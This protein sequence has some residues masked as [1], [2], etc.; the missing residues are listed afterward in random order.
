MSW[1]EGIVARPLDKDDAEAWVALNE[2]VQEADDGSEHESTEDFVAFL[3][4]PLLEQ[5]IGIWDGDTLVGYVGILVNDG[6]TV[7]VEAGG[8]VRPDR[9]RAGH[10]GR[11][12]DWARR[13]AT[14]A[15]A[16]RTPDRPG[17][18]QVAA[19]STNAGHRAML[20]GAGFEVVRHFFEM[21]HDLS[22]VSPASVPEGLRLVPFEAAYSEETRLAHNEAFRDHWGYNPRSP[23]VWAAR[24]VDNP[25]FRPEMSALLVDGERVAAY[26][27]GMEYDADTAATGVR[28]CHI[29]LV[30]TRREYRGR[31]AAGA[32]LAHALTNARERGYGTASLGVDAESPTGALGVYER[33]G[34]TVARTE[35][36][37][38][39]PLEAAT[40]EGRR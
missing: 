16:E 17:E 20:E 25:A 30:G 3:A 21:E 36:S 37:Y 19:L 7:R 1:P 14:E 11:L 26:L 8:A 31:G 4:D 2:A 39:L 35:L 33:V 28:D 38:S 15:Y 34:F 10:G 27:M 24:T 32:L 13:R 5:T 22:S 23:E 18:L 12:L 9:R 6:E 29:G 40:V